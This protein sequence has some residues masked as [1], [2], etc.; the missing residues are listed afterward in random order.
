MK[1]LPY[2]IGVVIVGISL[3]KTISKRGIEHLKFLEGERLKVYLDNANIPTVG[4]GHKVLPVDNLK[5]GDMITQK[6]SSSLLRKDLSVAKTAVNTQVKVPLNQSQYDALV[7]FVFNVG[8]YN[9]AESTLLEKL[10]EYDYQGALAEFPRWKYS[11]DANTGIKSINN[12]LVKRR[13]Y[14]QD[15]FN[16]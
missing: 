3:R 2:I 10:N 5:V 4:V 7:S 1:Y 16:A 15:L 8:I 9:F 14:E 13:K 6:K 12:G 11:T